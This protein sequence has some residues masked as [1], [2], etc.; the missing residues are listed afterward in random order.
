MSGPVGQGGLTAFSASKARPASRQQRQQQKLRAGAVR[1]QR[2][3]RAGRRDRGDVGELQRIARRDQQALLAAG[4]CDH[5]HVVQAGRVRDRVGVGAVV[6][7]V[8]PV[9][10]NGRRHDLAAGEPA[11]AGF[12]ALRQ[13]RE[14]R[15]A[16]AQRPFQ[17]RIV[18][19]ADDRR[20]RLRQRRGG[21]QPRRDPAVE[22]RLGKQ[23]AAGDLA[24][25]HGGV[26]DQLVELA[27]GQPEIGGGLIGG[28]KIG[29]SCT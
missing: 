11:Q 28:E 7:A 19:A 13:G 18:A 4:E 20:R 12:A 24:A 16:F 26:G 9:Q 15:S 1:P 3:A 27:L 6:V 8:D 22:R 5:H 10:V 2:D 14:P 29:H 25:R 17:Q 21:Q 23:P